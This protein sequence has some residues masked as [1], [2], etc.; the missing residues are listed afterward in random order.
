MITKLSN[1]QKI[2]LAAML[3]VLTILGTRLPALISIP[4]IPFV[5]LS[6]GP[7]LIILS[8]ILLGPLYGALIGAGSDL[9]GLVIFPSTGL[10]NIN[11]F[12][13]IIYGCLGILPWLLVFLTKK[14]RF[15]FKQPW[16]I[17]GVM[18]L[19]WVFVLVFLLMNNSIT[20]YGGKVYEFDTLSKTLIL[21]ISFILMIAMGISLFFVNKQFQKKVLEHPNL[22]SP[23]EIAFVSLICEFILMLIVGS[24][25]KSFMYEVDFLFI[26]FA[27]CIVFFIDVPLNTFV[28]SYLLLLYSKVNSNNGAGN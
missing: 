8:S 3:L 22:P 19:L 21:S 20:L 4:S 26:F 5:R 27:Q 12:I 6:L 14:I 10:S 24:L 25:V 13:T 15:T 16:I 7:S 9:L 23:Y 18:L 17:Y 11:P 1:V 2:T 28:V